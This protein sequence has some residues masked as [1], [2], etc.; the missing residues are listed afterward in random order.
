MM[1]SFY[2]GSIFS[3]CKQYLDE[4]NMLTALL[5]IQVADQVMMTIHLVVKWLLIRYA[6]YVAI[7]VLM[8]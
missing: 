5:D 7:S 3:D 1:I 2:R 8:I 4:D 6:S